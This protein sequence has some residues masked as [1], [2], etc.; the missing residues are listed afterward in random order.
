MAF[1]N[2]PIIPITS[3]SAQFAQCQAGISL[4]TNNKTLQLRSRAEQ[5]PVSRV[6]TIIIVMDKKSKSI[7]LW[8]KDQ[9]KDRVPNS[10]AALFSEGVWISLD[11]GLSPG[12]S[13]LF[14]YP[15]HGTGDSCGGNILWATEILSQDP[16]YQGI[17]GLTLRLPRTIPL[18]HWQDW[19]FIDSNILLVYFSL[20]L[21][22]K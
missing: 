2:C 14:R 6:Q 19:V 4:E 22:W 16:E 9:D 12:S 11:S 18:C 21:S 8:S 17:T 20:L 10:L 5:P 3:L 1:W 13:K 7:P 15:K